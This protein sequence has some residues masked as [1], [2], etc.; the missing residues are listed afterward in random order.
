M[1]TASNG[2]ISAKVSPNLFFFSSQ[3][4][5]GERKPPALRLYFLETFFFHLEKCFSDIKSLTST[6]S[7]VLSEAQT[8]LTRNKAEL[9]KPQS[10]NTLAWQDASC[11]NDGEN[12][13]HLMSLQRRTNE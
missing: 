8:H 9:D 2:S 4:S 11:F 7:A 1:P 10:A 13:K 12:Q 5:Q 6:N 3:I